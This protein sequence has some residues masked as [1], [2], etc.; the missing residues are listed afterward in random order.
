[1]YRMG[2]D[3]VGVGITM[4]SVC[5]YEKVMHHNVSMLL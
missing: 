4:K 2:W 3:R 5:S 1:M